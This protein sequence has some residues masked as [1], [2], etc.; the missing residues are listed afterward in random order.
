MAVENEEQYLAPKRPLDPVAEA[1]ANMGKLLVGAAAGYGLAKGVEVF[2]PE[3]RAVGFVL[4]L[5]LG[6][7]G[8]YLGGVVE[9]EPVD[10]A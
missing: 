6:V 3:P 1:F 7:V 2:I 8:G 4:E 9:V 5:G 10:P